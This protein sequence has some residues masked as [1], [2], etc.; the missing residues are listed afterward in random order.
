[1]KKGLGLMED[2]RGIPALKLSLIKGL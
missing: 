1:M 2:G